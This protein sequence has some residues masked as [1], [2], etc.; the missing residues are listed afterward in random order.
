VT[1][2]ALDLMAAMRLRKLVEAS[3]PAQL[4]GLVWFA[5]VALSFVALAIPLQLE[6]AW[7]T[8]GWALQSLA[9]L[10]LWKKIDHP[11]LKYFALAVAVFT[12]VRLILN[13]EIFEYHARSGKPIFNWLMYG[14]LLPAAALVGGANVLRQ[15][16]VERARP[17]E[18]TFYRNGNAWGAIKCFAGAILIV[19][20]WVNLTIFAA[21]SQGR[22]IEV[23]FD[24][25]AARDLTLSFVWGVFALSL[26]ALA[27]KTVDTGAALDELGVLVAD[28]WKG[29]LA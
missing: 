2:G 13:P 3:D 29:L 27:F 9:L 24:R 10:H 12:F 14:Y 11:G 28:D 1:L 19:F 7:I 18:M 17:F 20:A 22:M 25:L 16:E 23:S 15:L 26:L 21:F 4:R 8:I 6:K 5:G